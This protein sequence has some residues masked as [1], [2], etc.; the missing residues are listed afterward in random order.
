M[1][2]GVY[3][4]IAYP[5]SCDIKALCDICVGMG[6]EYEY[7]LHD[8]DAKKEHYHFLCGWQSH[9]PEWATFKRAVTSVGGVA[10][11]LRDCLVADV[12]KI[13]E[14]LVHK[15]DPHKFQYS[16]WYIV[17]SEGWDASAYETANAKRERE[18]ELKKADKVEL[19]FQVISLIEKFD[20]LEISD[21]TLRIAT[22]FHQYREILIEKHSYFDSYIRSKRN[23]AE[24]RLSL[25]LE[26]E[27][28]SK[29]VESLKDINDKL[30]EEN[31]MLGDDIAR[32]K[33]Q[34]INLANQ[35]DVAPSEHD[36]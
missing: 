33:L 30:E 12:S 28:L 20:I 1:S 25:I 14:Y 4:I 13:E 11:S 23:W 19:T 5:E 24:K 27:E 3:S 26:I 31:R 22:E 16:P 9:F 32:Y 35:N 15:N 21:L 7:I 6:A 36:F 17:S 29:Q 10:I 2:K 34:L 8:R 18:R